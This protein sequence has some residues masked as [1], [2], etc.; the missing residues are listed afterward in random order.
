MKDVDQDLP[1]EWREFVHMLRGLLEQLTVPRRSPTLDD[2]CVRM[3]A[4]DYPICDDV[5]SRYLRGKRFPPW[6]FAALLH[7]LACEDIG[8]AAVS[9]SIQELRSWY[10]KA[11][12][13]RKTRRCANCLVLH[14][15]AH[16]LRQRVAELLKANEQLEVVTHSVGPLARHLPVTPQGGDRQGSELETPS[17]PFIATESV[18]LLAA[19]Q[20]EAALTLVREIPDRLSPAEGAAS[21]AML[22]RQHE[23]LL[24]ETLVQFYSRDQDPKVVMRFVLE[25]QDSGSEDDAR[26]VLEAAVS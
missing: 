6:G 13:S 8:S 5:I 21:L 7:A 15:T 19:G 1:A 17:A 24:A 14:R 20:A 26:L 9:A 3:K 2:I 18:R 12:A 25:L 4:H 10:T 11:D 23:D 16:T 22:R